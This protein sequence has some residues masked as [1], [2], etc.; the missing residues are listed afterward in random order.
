LS[1]LSRLASILK[2]PLV[3]FILVLSKLILS[4]SFISMMEVFKSQ[5]KELVFI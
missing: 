2:N 5:S 3:A 1:I 4:G